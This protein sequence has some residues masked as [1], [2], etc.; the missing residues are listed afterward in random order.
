M[1]GQKQNQKESC[2]A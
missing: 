2:G 1:L